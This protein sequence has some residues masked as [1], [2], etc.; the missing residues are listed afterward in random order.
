[1]SN[2]D[3]NCQDVFELPE[4]LK[5]LTK[6]VTCCIIVLLFIHFDV[7]NIYRFNRKISNYVLVKEV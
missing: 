1:M 6:I 4:T 7:G 3:Y 2:V 5:Y